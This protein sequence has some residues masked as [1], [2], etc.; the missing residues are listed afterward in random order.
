MNQNQDKSVFLRLFQIISD[1]LTIVK[2]ELELAKN[3]LTYSAKKLGLG[4]SFLIISLFLILIFLLFILITIAFVFV[5]LGLN[6]WLAFLLVAVIMLGISV[7]FAL[8]GFRSFRK[9][10][11]ISDATKIGLETRKYLSENINKFKN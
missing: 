9:M 6:L 2:A 1:V 7:V 10:K 5:A 3:N 4:I 11:G 8:L